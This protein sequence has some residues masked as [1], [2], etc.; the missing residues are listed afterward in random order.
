MANR[1]NGRRGNGSRGRDRGNLYARPIPE[2][3][4]FVELDLS[5]GNDAA[6]DSVITGQE[7]LNL[8]TSVVPV[9]NIQKF[10][11]SSVVIDPVVSPTA[12]VGAGDVELG[13]SGLHYQFAQSNKPLKMRLG[14][15]YGDDGM[16]M[17]VD[18]SNALASVGGWS[19]G[20]PFL[21]VTMPGIVASWS[22]QV[23]F[24]I[25]WQDPS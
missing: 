3:C 10:R 18:A 12:I 22:S 14:K 9:T 6:G 16:W 19:A 2:P 4:N 7:I 25:A 8:L 20:D 17:V 5:I 15:E 21:S 13:I 23:H 24:R 11:V 1:R